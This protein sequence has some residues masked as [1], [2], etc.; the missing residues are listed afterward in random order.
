[1]RESRSAWP[2][3]TSASLLAFIVAIAAAVASTQPMPDCMAPMP[4]APADWPDRSQR[5]SRDYGSATAVDDGRA[6]VGMRLD[7]I[8]DLQGNQGSAYVF[9]R[10]PD[11]SWLEVAKLTDEFGTVDSMLG[12]A[13]ALAGDRALI[14][15]P[16]DPAELGLNAGTALVYER[17][18]DASWLPVRLSPSEVHV[19]ALL[20]AAVAIQD[21]RAVVGAPGFPNGDVFVFER[22]PVLGWLETQKLGAV[23]VRRDFGQAVDLDRDRILIGADDDDIASFS[24]AALL[25][26]RDSQGIWQR[27]I[28]LKANDAASQDFFGTEVAIDGDRAAVAAG[29]A[30]AVYLFERDGSGSWLQT[31]RLEPPDDR[32]PNFGNGVITFGNSVDLRGDLL[33]IGAGR[34]PDPMS[35]TAPTVLIYGRRAADDWQLLDE[36]D[37]S[38]DNRFPDA[39]FA[40]MSGDCIVSGGNGEA[41]AVPEP[42]GV[43]TLAAA[44]AVLAMISARRRR[45]AAH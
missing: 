12:S 22:D 33:L 24:G 27:V 16:R 20:G 40:T 45:S 32:F 1:M 5:S 34:T 29:P 4:L 6:L 21:D 11:G 23:D 13:V 8:G 14:G 19:T 2:I 9:D 36:L 41:H 7:D 43:E 30:S 17:Q 3:R 15:A 44:L 39:A 31:D 25:F 18:P 42:A 37:F 10:Q 35:L 26:E 38:T 28:K